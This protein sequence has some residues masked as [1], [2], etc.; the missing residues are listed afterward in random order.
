MQWATE[1][2]GDWVTGGA[3][4]DWTSGDGGTGGRRTQHP[5]KHRDLF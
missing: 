1:K 3:H 2:H 5:K 4:G